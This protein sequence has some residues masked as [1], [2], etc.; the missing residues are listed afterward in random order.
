[1]DEHPNA[2]R[3]LIAGGLLLAAVALGLCLAGQELPSA[4]VYPAPEPENLL[5]EPAAWLALGLLDALGHAAWVLVVGWAAVGV[6]LLLGRG[7]AAVAAR[8]AGW[9]LLL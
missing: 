1:M 8:A 7:A 3:P 2:H 4:V 6:L 9:V 5:G